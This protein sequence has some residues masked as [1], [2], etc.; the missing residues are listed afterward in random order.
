MKVCHVV[1]SSVG[2]VWL[3]EQ[4]RELRDQYGYD[5]T[6]C[7]SS[8]RGP[9]IDALRADKIP[10]R[11]GS[12]ACPGIPGILT[13]PSKVLR[14]ARLL[15]REKFDLVQ[16]HLF[17]S[18]LIGRLAAWLADVPVRLAMIAG[19]H[20]LETHT[21][22]WI[23]RSTC[24]MESAV[25]A[26]CEYTGRLYRRMGVPDARLELIYY[27]PD[28]RR[29]N[30]DESR[31]ANLRRE[32]GWPAD[33]PLIGMV[34][35]FYTPDRRSGR[36]PPG[37]RGRGIKGHEY[38][39]KAMPAILN[40][41]PTVKLLLIGAPMVETGQEILDELKALVL[42]LG[43]QGRIVFT[44]FRPDVAACMRAPHGG[45]LHDAPWGAFRHQLPLGASGRPGHVHELHSA[46]R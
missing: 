33:T 12:F 20:H 17:R 38:L 32:Y 46:G 4:L 29:F 44:G 31:A 25:I 37:M 24:W 16:T 18:M 11:V 42:Q 45:A 9:L 2:C 6:A 36:T 10:F 5:V 39:I 23:D 7:V 26:S 43:L 15:R 35:Y 30:P 3:V 8:D 21:L 1:D 13:L 22:R 27:G 34:A 41:F 14:L 28:E 19:P 40:E